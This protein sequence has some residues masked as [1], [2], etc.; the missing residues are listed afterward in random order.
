M[1]DPPEDPDSHWFRRFRFSADQ[2]DA[3][4][5]Q[6]ELSCR[7]IDGGLGATDLL[8]NLLELAWALP[9]LDREV[10]AVAFGRLAVEVARAGADTEAEIEGLLHTATA[11]QYAGEPVEARALFQ[12]GIDLA[13]RSG[14]TGSL[15]YLR[16]HLGRLMAEGLDPAAAGELFDAALE[17]RR[18][19][20]DAGLI[21]STETARAELAAWIDSHGRASAEP[22]PADTPDGACDGDGPGP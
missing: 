14:R 6:V 16:H 11:L 17:Q 7:A 21:R 4:R 13:L 2:A 9:P 15:H 8:A 5:E 22:A 1:T 10:E 19:V 18:E 12:A 20:G 3:V